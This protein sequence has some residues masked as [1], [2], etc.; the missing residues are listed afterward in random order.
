MKI[1][2]L[3]AYETAT[4]QAGAPKSLESNDIQRSIALEDDLKA[5]NSNA[6]QSRELVPIH[7]PAK[8]ETLPEE[9][10]PRP[11]E[12]KDG[13]QD[14]FPYNVRQ[15][16]PRE[17]TELGQELYMEGVLSF[18]EYSMLSF[19]SELHPDYDKTIGALTGQPAQPDSP[20]D[21][22]AQWQEKLTFQKEHNAS[23]PQL[24]ARTER[25]LN[26]LKMIDNPTDLSA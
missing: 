14:L 16:S 22:I 2:G 1:E 6:H 8:V 18:E 19:Q 3:G 20:R 26:I 23:Q 24:I 21:Y 11:R 10:E 15:M 5:A 7:L 12:E 13:T 9:E 25:I 17:A 4:A